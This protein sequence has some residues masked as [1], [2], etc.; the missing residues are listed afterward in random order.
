M[1]MP[2]RKICHSEDKLCHAEFIS[3]SNASH[4]THAAQDD[5]TVYSF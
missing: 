2:K 4:A 5:T 3:A 1:L